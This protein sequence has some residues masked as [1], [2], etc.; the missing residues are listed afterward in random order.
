MP[1]FPTFLRDHVRTVSENIMSVRGFECIGLRQGSA[2]CAQTD[3][4]THM[5]K[6]II[7]GS[8]QSLRS[9]GGYNKQTQAQTTSS[10][11]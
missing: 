9:L 5:H 3:R 10:H 11:T 6:N 4:Q 8:V 2:I 1:P 7:S